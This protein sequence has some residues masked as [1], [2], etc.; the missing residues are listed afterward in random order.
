MSDISDYKSSMSDHQ[1]L[2]AE[3]ADFCRDNGMAESTF[4]QKAVH[5]W[6][7][8]ERLRQGR[9]TMRTIERVRAFLRA[10]SGNEDAPRRR[11]SR[12]A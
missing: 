2:L 11:R 8:V 7:L 1:Q 3:I 4:G 12:A 5:E 10:A 6:R 9:V